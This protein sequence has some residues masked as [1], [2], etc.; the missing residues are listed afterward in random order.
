MQISEWIW[1]FIQEFT[2]LLLPLWNTPVCD[3]ASLQ[4]GYGELYAAGTNSPEI[5]Q[6]D[7]KHQGTCSKPLVIQIELSGVFSMLIFSLEAK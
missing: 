5:S 7:L 6:V 4:T 2:T 1:S 3:I